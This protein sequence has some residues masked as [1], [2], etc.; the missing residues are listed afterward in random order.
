MSKRKDPSPGWIYLLWCV[1]TTRFKIGYS[2]NVRQRAEAIECQ[3]PYPLKVVAAKP[4]IVRDE[5]DL[6]HEF[7][8]YCSHREWFDLPEDAVWAL[9]RKFGISF[10]HAYTVAHLV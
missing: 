8:C 4:G 7:R 2:R 3:S 9:L 6:H 1:G 10:D 5:Q